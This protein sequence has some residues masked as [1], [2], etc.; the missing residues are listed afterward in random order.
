MNL[1]YVDWLLA[2]DKK[3]IS[4]VCGAKYGCAFA[5]HTINMIMSKTAIDV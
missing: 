4:V 3:R 2:K 1:K 5:G